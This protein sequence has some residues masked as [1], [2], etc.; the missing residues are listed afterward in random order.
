MSLK[1]TDRNKRIVGVAL[2][3]R[4]W[5]RH[6]VGGDKQSGSEGFE[7]YC[8]V[9]GWHYAPGYVHISAA[10]PQWSPPEAAEEMAEI[11]GLLRNEIER[12]AEVLDEKV[13]RLQRMEEQLAEVLKS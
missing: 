6:A 12:T 1:P 3:A 11:M 8:S 7:H 4:D 9:G 5:A 2:S 10:Q 13:I